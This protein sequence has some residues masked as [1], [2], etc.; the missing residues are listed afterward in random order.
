MSYDTF[1]LGC[2]PMYPECVAF[3]RETM[4][5]RDALILL[6]LSLSWFCAKTQ[7]I[8]HTWDGTLTHICSYHI[9]HIYAMRPFSITAALA[10]Y[11][12]SFRTAYPQIYDIFFNI[13]KLKVRQSRQ[14]T[15]GYSK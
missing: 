7:R 8:P 14:A 9:Y 5:V 12:R 2:R 11:S 15:S 1:K 13:K 10:P 6:S 3:L 4:S